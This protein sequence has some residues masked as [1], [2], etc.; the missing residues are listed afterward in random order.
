MDVLFTLD[1]LLKDV[2][3]ADTLINH[4]TEYIQLN[5]QKFIRRWVEFMFLEPK[6][7]FP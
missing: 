6:I 3:K 2:G 5:I 1:L 7:I 4:M